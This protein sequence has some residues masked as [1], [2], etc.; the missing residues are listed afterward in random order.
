MSDAVGFKKPKQNKKATT[1]TTTT[2]PKQN[3]PAGNKAE[4]VAVLEK[5]HKHVHRRSCFAIKQERCRVLVPNY[6]TEE[7]SIFPDS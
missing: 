7:I 3:N 4:S 1:T 6:L 5:N 2:T